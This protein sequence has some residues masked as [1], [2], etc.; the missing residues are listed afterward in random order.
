[1]LLEVVDFALQVGRHDLSPAVSKKSGFTVGHLGRPVKGDGP[2]R[3]TWT[4]PSASTILKGSE[5]RGLSPRLPVGCHWL[6]QC[7]WATCPAGHWQSQWH[8]RHQI[9]SE[10]LPCAGSSVTLALGK[11]ST[12][13]W[14]ACDAWNIGATTAPAWPSSTTAA[15]WP[16]A[17]RPAASSSSRP[18]W[19]SRPCKAAPASAIPAGPPTACLPTSMPIP[20]WEGTACWPWPI[21]A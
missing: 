1:M 4:P 11:R 6:R 18:V 7:L 19:P 5:P 3:D 10:E 9:A 15:N 16:S 20:I 17:N 13:C 8:T 14:A 21:T 12:T 2:R